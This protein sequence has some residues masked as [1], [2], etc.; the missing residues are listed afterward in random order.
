M[1]AGRVDSEGKIG[2]S[3]VLFNVGYV[4]FEMTVRY[5]SGWPMA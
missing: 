2:C 3:A 4:K 5:T 1:T